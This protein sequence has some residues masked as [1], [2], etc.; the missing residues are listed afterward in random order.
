MT[1]MAD[2]VD[3]FDEGRAGEYAK[4]SRIALAGYEACHEL[5]ACLLSAALGAN[6]EAQILVVGAGG[7]AQ[8]IIAMSKL[9]PNWSYTGVDPSE[10][11]LR[12]SRDSLARNGLTSRTDLH[13]GYVNDLKTES[14]FDA[15]TLIGV[16]HHLSGAEEKRKLLDDIACKL[17]PG[18]P[19]ILAGNRFAYASKPLFLS[20][21]AERWRMSGTSREEVESKRAKIL[22]GADPPAS[23]EAVLNL[24]EQAGFTEA[25]QFFSSLF[26]SAWIAR[27][28]P[29]QCA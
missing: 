16:I 15:A 2:S 29:R 24:L 26:W 7:T 28:T 14:S 23:N 9:A 21:W 1:N 4:Q 6:C 17:K 20:A 22:Q 12:L 19:F 5:A 27:Y 11:M 10:S 3:K 13:M 18:A 8:E 25:E